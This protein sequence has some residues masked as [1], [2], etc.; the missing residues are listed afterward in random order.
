MQPL[1]DDEEKQ[2]LLD[3]S[4]RIDVAGTV[5]NVSVETSSFWIDSTQ[6]VCGKYI[7][8]AIHACLDKNR[9]W[10]DPQTVLPHT[11][12]IIAFTGILDRFETYI[13]PKSTEKLACAVVAV[14]DI[15]FLQ[16]RSEK[17]T[18]TTNKAA[19]NRVKTR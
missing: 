8:F 7:R 13:A 14:E 9:K 1:S 15:T 17:K 10:K 2:A 19:R 12:S 4:M 6:Y 16:P 18:G 11:N 3:D 5:A